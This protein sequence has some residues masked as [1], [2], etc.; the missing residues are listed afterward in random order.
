MEALILTIDIAL[1][2]V[3]LRCVVGDQGGAV[4]PVLGI[5]QYRESGGEASPKEGG[6]DHA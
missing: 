3:L 1:M 4:A 5:F 2:V 6:A